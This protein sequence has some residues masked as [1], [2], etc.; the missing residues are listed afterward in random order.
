MFSLNKLSGGSR[1]ECAALM[2][3]W[4]ASFRHDSVSVGGTG[5]AATDVAAAAVR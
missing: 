1:L 4:S 3:L 2:Y 5:G